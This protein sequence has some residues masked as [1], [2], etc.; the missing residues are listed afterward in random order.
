MKNVK[1][2]TSDS[3]H[4]SLVDTLYKD[5]EKAAAYIEV[6]L[7]DGGDDP[8]LLPAVIKDVIEAQ[9]RHNNLSVSAKEKWDKLEKI[10]SESKC[11]E[12]YALVELLD[13]LGF[14]L[15]VRV[16]SKGNEPVV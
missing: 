10:L 14:K 12:I 5:S 6:T 2:P 11:A 8:S 4:D 16:V 13:A 3:W 7:E 1:I 9:E 15:E